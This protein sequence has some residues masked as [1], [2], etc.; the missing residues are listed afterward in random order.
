[1]LFFCG[2]GMDFDV[3]AMPTLMGAIVRAFPAIP[4]QDLLTIG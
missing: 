3:N 2:K 4:V 1:M